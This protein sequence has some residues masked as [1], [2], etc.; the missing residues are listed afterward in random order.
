MLIISLMIRMC[1]SL[2]PLFEFNVP[3]LAWA[4]ALNV[5]HYHKVL[6]LQPQPNDGSFVG[7]NTIM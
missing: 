2:K 1:C 7:Y 4:L 6:P 5:M 3:P